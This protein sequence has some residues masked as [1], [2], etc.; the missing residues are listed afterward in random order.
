MY[1]SNIIKPSTLHK[2]L[3]NSDGFNPK[4]NCIPIRPLLLIRIESCSFL[5]KFLRPSS[6][7]HTQPTT[8]LIITVNCRIRHLPSILSHVQPKGPPNHP[9]TFWS[10]GTLRV[11]FSCLALPGAWQDLSSRGA[12]VG[13]GWKHGRL[14]Y[15]D[16]QMH[17]WGIYYEWL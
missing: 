10:P 8:P 5:S 9:S 16:W 7:Y 15:R 17:W 14:G 4:Q 1:K 11:Q 12:Q 3:T 13:T 6:T 2:Q